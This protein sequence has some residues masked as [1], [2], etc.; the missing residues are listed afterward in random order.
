MY[1]KQTP[2]DILTGMT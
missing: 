2:I 1:I